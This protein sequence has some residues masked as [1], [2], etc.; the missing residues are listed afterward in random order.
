MRVGK[1]SQQ[2]TGLRLDSLAQASARAIR[3]AG[4]TPYQLGRFLVRLG[5]ALQSSPASPI[6]QPRPPAPPRSNGKT[7]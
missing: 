5:D 1:R 2:V 6:T 3:D 4:G 7:R